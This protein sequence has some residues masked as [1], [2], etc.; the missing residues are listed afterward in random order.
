MSTVPLSDHAPAE[1]YDASLRWLVASRSD[2]HV[3]YVCELGDSPGYS[4][5]S[6]PDFEIHFLPLL[7]RG[8]SPEAALRAGLV[9]R[10]KYHD[11]DADVLLCWHCVQAYRALAKATVRSLVKARELSRHDSTTHSTPQSH[12]TA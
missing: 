3:T 2:P 10:R 4:V 11:S 7:R 5:C 8:V 6:C 12:H 1:L 9:K